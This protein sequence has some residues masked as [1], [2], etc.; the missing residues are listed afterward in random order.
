MP[1]CFR[2]HWTRR[3]FLA[4][5]AR[6]AAAGAGAAAGLSAL[7][8]AARDPERREA[9]YYDRLPGK[10]IQCHVCPLN[11]ILEDGQ[12][13]FCR[14][15][16]NIG[17]RLYNTAFDR[18]CLLSVDPIEKTPFAHVL[19]G[20]QLL[21]VAA[22][23]CNL[24]CLYCQNWEQSQARPQDLRVLD[25]SRDEMISGTQE[26]KCIG[27]CYTYTEPV[28]YLDYLRAIVDEARKRSLKNF[29]ATAAFVNE[30]PIRDLAREVD[31]F[32]VSIKGWRDEVYEK[33]CSVKRAPV[34]DALRVVKEE[35]RWLE[36]VYVV[37]PTYNDDPKEA[38]GMARWACENLGADTPVHF[39]RFFP[40]Y[41]MTDLPRT[42]VQSIDACVAAARE[43][44]LRYVYVTNLAPHEANHTVCADCGE[45]V[46][47]R[48]GFKV[49]E[50]RSKGGKCPKCSRALPGIWT[51]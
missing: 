19:P 36:L 1:I 38:S 34:L 10:R 7:T 22:G 30:R 24:R 28:A 40:E 6:L 8:A 12:T 47:R 39:A 20:T 5:A 35:K 46:V 3:E 51:A 16:T 33:V 11:C 15:R 41:K 23:G 4:A 27:L 13:C 49:L 25:V 26:K 44:G 48:L 45:M 50:D 37:I 2:P 9:A 21:S 14:T 43:A 32:C 31:G 18:P 29:V 17:G 42:P